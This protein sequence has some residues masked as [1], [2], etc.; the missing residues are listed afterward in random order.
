MT[1]SDLIMSFQFDLATLADDP[2]LRRLLRSNPIPGQ[3]TLTYEREPNYFLGCGTM[4]HFYQILAARHQPSGEVVG[5]ASRSTRPLFINGQVE[6]VGYIGQLR[7]AAEHQGR[8]VVS[9]GFRLLRELH[10][11]GRVQGYITTII[12]GNNQAQGVLV[13]R[14]RRTFPAYREVDRLCTLA[15]ILRRPKKSAPTPFDIHPAS[16]NDLGDI[17][18]FLRTYGAAKQ[19][20]PVYQES[21]FISQPDLQGLDLQGVG[22]LAGFSNQPDLQ[23]DL[24]GVGNLAS[25]SNQPDLQPDLQGVGNLAGLPSQA[26][27]RDFAPTDFIVARRQG[28]IVGVIGLWD[29]TGYKQTV[30]QAYH[31]SLRRWRFLYNLALRLAGARPLTPPGHK[32]HFAYASFICVADNDPAIFAG[33]LRAAYNLAATRGYAYLMVGLSE[34]DPLLAVARRTWHIPYYSRLYTVCWAEEAAFHDKL[35]GRV[36][37]VEIAAL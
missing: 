29:Q 13:K 5:V 32:I 10:A 21:D 37:Y 28:R 24:Q 8:W 19:F 11:D 30:V 2:A 26:L 34:R 27:T 33:L 17:V 6:E 1:V 15:I 25:F 31:G 9:G 3:V 36:P 18:H 16:A 23:P 22:N 14:A 20:F 12:E 4:G 7:V 35:D